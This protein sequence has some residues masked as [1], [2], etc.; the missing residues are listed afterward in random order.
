[1]LRKDI[2]ELRLGLRVLD[3]RLVR[4][5][6]PTG[7]AADTGLVRLGAIAR[8][9]LP[10]AVAARRDG[11]VGDDVDA[12]PARPGQVSLVGGDLLFVDLGHARADHAEFHP[13]AQGA[14]IIGVQL[15][16]DHA[17]REQ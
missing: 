16:F 14:E 15:Q 8:I 3:T 1:M 5:R 6:T 17:R 10:Q 2:A 11:C 7:Q 4:P 12:G 9:S 13:L